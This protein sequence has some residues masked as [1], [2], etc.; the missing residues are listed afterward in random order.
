MR[1]SNSR[2]V[3]ATVF[4]YF[5]FV[6][7]L[8]F[9]GVLLY[10]PL[11]M[12]I[13]GRNFR[14]AEDIVP[15]LL[16]ANLFLGMFLYLSQWYKQTEKVLYGAYVSIGGAVITL[17]INYI[18]IPEYGYMASAWATLAAYSCMAIVSWFWGQ[19]HFPVNYNIVSITFYVWFA[20]ALYV[21]S[22]IIKDDMFDGDWTIGLYFLNTILGAVYII[23]FIA[24]E[25][26]SFLLGL[27]VIRNFKKSHAN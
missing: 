8:I 5:S 7:S 18:F 23:V 26:P 9:L 22:R 19:K 4:K 17:V 2:D 14:G 3:Y 21:I 11:A 13:I 27:P 20:V 10:L 15:I 25:K 24:T 16:M 1:E 12:K 6:T